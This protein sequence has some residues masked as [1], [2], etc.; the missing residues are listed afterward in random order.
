MEEGGGASKHL[1]NIYTAVNHSRFIYRLVHVLFLLGREKKTRDSCGVFEWNSYVKRV[2]VSQHV[3]HQG[4]KLTRPKHDSVFFQ[5]KALWM[6]TKSVAYRGEGQNLLIV[7][8]V[9]GIVLLEVHAVEGK[10][11][12]QIK[13][14]KENRNLLDFHN[15]NMVSVQIPQ[16]WGQDHQK[17]TRSLTMCLRWWGQIQCSCGE[18]TERGTVMCAARESGQSCES[19]C[20]RTSWCWD[21][22]PCYTCFYDK[23]PTSKTLQCQDRRNDDPGNASAG[24]WDWNRDPFYTAFTL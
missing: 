16:S 20:R 7:Q 14:R 9:D 2:T 11:I 21:Q 22:D 19:A 24:L 13:T 17:K 5:T 8:F 23:L 1:Q 12:K 18:R 10:K 6:R 15:K 3:L 4:G